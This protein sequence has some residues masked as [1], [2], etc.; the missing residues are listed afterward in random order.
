MLT[1]FHSPL[2]AVRLL[3]LEAGARI[4]EH[5]DHML[6]LADGEARLHIPVATNPDVDF[7]VAGRRLVLNVGETWYIDFSLPHRVANRGTTARVHL[8]IDC[9]ANDWLRGLLPPDPSPESGSIAATPAP[10]FRPPD[11]AADLD[12]FRLLVLGE[13]A[14]EEELREIV[15]RELFIDR[16]VRLAAERGY[17][18]TAGDVAEAMRLGR[19]ALQEGVVA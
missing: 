2:R 15:D 16:V 17:D 3:R 18:V 5:R 1:H 9:A 10:S 7:V 13:P 6:G 12:S 19:R 11:A 4:R 14:L 8:V